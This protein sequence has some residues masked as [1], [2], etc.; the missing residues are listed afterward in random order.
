M[1]R[2]TALLLGAATLAA[3]VV[4]LAF[5]SGGEVPAVAHAGA[6]GSIAGTVQYSGTAPQRAVLQMAADPFCVTA[7]AGQTVLSEQ[8][9]VNDNSTLRWTFVHIREARSGSLPAG[10]GDTAV[11]NQVGCMYD[12][13]VLGMQAGSTIRVVNS[14]QTLHNVNAQPR[15]NQS[16]NIA[17]PV[18]GMATERVFENPEVMIP[19]RC[20]VHPWMQAY[21]GVVPHGFFDVSGEDGGFSMEGVPPGEYVVEAWHESLGTQTLTVTVR[22]GETASADFTFGSDQ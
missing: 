8:V 13:H 15:N 7:H 9:V 21:I 6:A 22:E 17:Q 16:F 10:A 12:P 19:V 5:L 2:S 14:D 4:A 11:L 1:V 20:D 3:L 18:P